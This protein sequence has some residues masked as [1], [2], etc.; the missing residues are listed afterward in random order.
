MG[1]YPSIFQAEN[2]VIRS[3]RHWELLSQQGY[4]NSDCSHN[5][6]ELNYSQL[7]AK[8]IKWLCS[9]F[10]GTEELREMR[11][12]TYRTSFYRRSNWRRN[13]KEPSF[14]CNS[15]D[16]RFLRNFLEVREKKN[17]R[18]FTGFSS[19]HCLQK[20]IGLRNC[21]FCADEEETPDQPV[22]FSKTDSAAGVE[23]EGGTVMKLASAQILVTEGTHSN[24]YNLESTWLASLCC[25]QRVRGRVAEINMSEWEIGM[26]LREDLGDRNLCDRKNNKKKMEEW[27][28]TEWHESEKGRRIYEMC[29]KR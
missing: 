22:F 11:K 24:T 15:L 27:I 21:R 1:K 17:L 7:M 8:I 23:A 29:R 3:V 25:C 2:V 28:M 19:G 4:C 12:P 16:W 18:S 26:G 6:V 9:G 10:K 13:T 14:G 5:S 20:R